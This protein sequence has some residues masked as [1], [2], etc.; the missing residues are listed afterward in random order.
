M[1]FID[2]LK[3]FPDSK[4]NSDENKNLEISFFPQIQLKILVSVSKSQSTVNDLI[5]SL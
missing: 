3:T 4:L 5:Y 1:D 2:F